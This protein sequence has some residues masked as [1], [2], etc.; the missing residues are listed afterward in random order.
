MRDSW[1]PM[2]REVNQIIW[3]KFMGD[4]GQ[5][6]DHV[7]QNDTFEVRAYSWYDYDEEN[8]SED[9]NLWHFW[10]KPSGLKIAWYKYPLRGCI[11]NKHGLSH[12]FFLEVMKDCWNSMQGDQSVKITYDV[13]EW[14]SDDLPL[15]PLL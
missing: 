13:N 8:D 15:K 3:A 1:Y 11:C 4:L 14:W 6:W 5:D 10:H 12:E 2:E 7:M 9:S